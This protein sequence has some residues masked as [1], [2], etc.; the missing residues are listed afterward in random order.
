MVRW[1]GGVVC[2]LLVVGL[3]AYLVV[4]GLDKADKIASVLAAL[5]ALVALAAPYL[6]PA[7]RGV[8]SP[9]L[10]SASGEGAVAIG[11]DSSADVSTDVSS[12]VRP[13]RPGGM[14]DGVSASGTASVAVGGASTAEIRTR[15]TGHR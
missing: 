5:L 3:V 6:V 10:V 1:V 11:S 12:G 8:A 14:D 4:A 15:V 2:V 13:S 7:P 9:A